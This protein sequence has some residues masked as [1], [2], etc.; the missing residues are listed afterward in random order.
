[1]GHVQDLW[2][3]RDPE[4][5]K[6]VRSARYGKGKRWQAR[7]TAPDGNEPTRT[8]TNQDAAKA[9]VA[10]M[11]TSVHSGTY[12][13]PRHGRITFREYA[14]KWRADQLHHRERTVQQAEERLR[15]HIYPSIGSMQIAAIRRPHVQACV[16]KIAETLAPSTTEVTYGYMAA[17]FKSAVLDGI[18]GKT[19]CVKINLPELIRKK[20]VPLTMD[21]V[22]EICRNVPDRYRAAVIVCAASGVRQG[23]LFGLKVSH[24]EGSCDNVILRIEEQGRG[25]ATKTQ[26]S[27]RK[28]AIGLYASRALWKHLAT[29]REGI[30]GHVFSTVLRSR[31]HRNTASDIWRAATAGMNVR[32][33]SG[34]HDLRH[35][36]ASLLISAGLSVVAVADRLGHKD[37]TETLQTY[38][39]LWPTDHERAVAAVDAALGGLARSVR[40][41]SGPGGSVKVPYAGSRPGVSSSVRSSDVSAGQA[42][43]QVRQAS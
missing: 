14:E 16:N 23:E 12:I 20:V 5:G 31:V 9:H 30:G 35:H 24:L 25:T 27:E 1:M 41:P 13:D 10:A 3:K 32:E 17:V 40:V 19:P 43:D 11:E 7:W 26:S 8:F 36:H 4:T 18:I 28:V 34:W 39:H 37:G 33:R 22:E 6:K 29:Y 42:P 38:G 15:K 2:M 21:Q